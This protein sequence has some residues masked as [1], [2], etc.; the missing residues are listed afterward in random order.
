MLPSVRP[1]EAEQTRI[2]RQRIL[3]PHK[4]TYELVYPGDDAPDSLHV[5]AFEEDELV[6]VASVMREQRSGEDDP[7][8]WRIRGMATIPEVR[9]HGHGGALLE[10][11]LV[12]VAAHGGT[13]AWCTA[14]VT[15]M[16]FYRHFGF[17]AQGEPFE[18][19]VI[20]THYVMTRLIR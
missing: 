8:A 13:L 14:R 10:R 9:G 12:H 19:P 20:G 16:A 2:L 3:R 7:G 15:A 17:E 5:G 11:C 6:G 4:Q 1:I 18:V